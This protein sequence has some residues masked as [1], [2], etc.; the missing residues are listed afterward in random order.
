MAQG[1]D[2]AQRDFCDQDISV[3]ELKKNISKLKDNK[4]P[5]NDG[6]TGEFYKVF[7]DY[8]SEYYWFL[9]RL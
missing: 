4:S 2:E 6:L 1:I 5:G 7:Q 3:D 9:R 8:I